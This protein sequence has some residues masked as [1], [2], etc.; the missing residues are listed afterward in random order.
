V[1]EQQD[2]VEF[3]HAFLDGVPQPISWLVR[4]RSVNCLYS[5]AGEPFSTILDDFWNIELVVHEMPNLEASVRDYLDAEVVPEYRLDGKLQTIKKTLRIQDLPPVLFVQ[6]RRFRYDPQKRSRVKLDAHFE[7]PFE[8]FD[9]TPF[10]VNP[11]EDP[12]LYDLHGVVI[13]CGTAESGHYT[14]FIRKEGWWHFDD[15]T[16]TEVSIDAVKNAAFGNPGQGSAYI[17]VYAKQGFELEAQS[18]EKVSFTSEPDLSSFSNQNEMKQDNLRFRQTQSIFQPCVCDF[19]SQL[20][21]LPLLLSYITNILCHSTVSQG[22]KECFDQ[23][24]S[25][26]TES[27]TV[28]TYIMDHFDAVTANLIHCGSNTVISHFSDLISR[29]LSRGDSSTC[30]QCITEIIDISRAYKKDF[31]QLPR[32]I[33]IVNEVLTAIVSTLSIA[34][35]SEWFSQLRTLLVDI[36]TSGLT[37]TS[38]RQMKLQSLLT[39]LTLLLSHLSEMDCR[40]VL[41]FSTQILESESHRTAYS[42]LLQICAKRHQLSPSDTVVQLDHSPDMT[43]CLAKFLANVVSH[44]R[45]SESLS[46]L[47]DT[48]LSTRHADDMLNGFFTHALSISKAEGASVAREILQHPP[49]VFKPLFTS[50]VPDCRKEC[51]GLCSDLVEICREDS[52]FLAEQVLPPW[53]DLVSRELVQVQP[54]QSSSCVDFAF[55]IRFWHSLTVAAKGLTAERLEAVM[56][57]VGGLAPPGQSD[58]PNSNPLLEF[59]VEFSVPDIL[60]HISAITHSSLFSATDIT[61]RTKFVEKIMDCSEEFDYRPFYRLLLSQSWFRPTV[62]Q[63][64]RIIENIERFGQNDPDL[65][66]WQKI[67]QSLSTAGSPA[68]STP[69]KSDQ[70]PASPSRFATACLDALA[71]CPSQSPISPS[72]MTPLLRDIIDRTNTK[73]VG[74]T[75]PDLR[76]IVA[77]RGE[78]EAAGVDVA[79]FIRWCADHDSTFA[80]RLVDKCTDVMGTSATKDAQQKWLEII[81]GA[82]VKCKNHAS[83]G[84]LMDKNPVVLNGFSE[85]FAKKLEA[86]GTD[87]KW[88]ETV[89]TNLLVKKQASTEVKKFCGLVIPLMTVQFVEGERRKTQ[90]KDIAPWAKELLNRPRRAQTMWSARSKAPSTAVTTNK[91][92]WGGSYVQQAGQK[93]RTP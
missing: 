53:D 11:T 2:A 83:L 15:D 33:G 4:G 36:F 78:W 26:S 60:A 32:L 38:F 65:A 76:P 35:I 51:L 44:R 27:D 62:K 14:S 72:V 3:L 66:H 77:H 23:V 52:Q 75:A 89:V 8:D 84:S 25:L 74:F 57:A 85:F 59:L 54:P 18:G 61:I 55:I 80:G 43:E 1:R 41:E 16:T 46:G 56:T 64:A 19:V 29:A 10:L 24:D 31:A 92:I 71:Q 42:D 79:E 67:R 93:P 13:H 22:I 5:E 70:K 45:G 28:A 87:R 12:E 90:S 82:V 37:S 17:L 40:F 34:Q 6:L 48:V 73:Q 49:A 50:R 47:F 9:L 91:G 30:H 39:S 58:R 63:C 68:K 20:A 21:D 69:A 86:E 7:F 81:A 88:V